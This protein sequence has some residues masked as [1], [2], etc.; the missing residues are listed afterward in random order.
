MFVNSWSLFPLSLLLFTPLPA[1][2]QEAPRPIERPQPE[3]PRP[4]PKVLPP[5]IAPPEAPKFLE[6]PATSPS[7]IQVLRYEVI[8]STVFSSEKLSEITKP[9][10]GKVS[11]DQL[12][13]AAQAITDYYLKRNYPT[14][15]A[16]VPSGQEL[17]PDNAIVQ[18]QVLE[19]KLEDIKVTG[20]QRLKSGYIQSRLA[21]ATQAP[22][23]Y[24]RLVESIRLLQQNPLLDQV[25][26]ELSAGKQP[27]TNLLEI[28]VKESNPLNLQILTENSRSPS[29]GSWQRRIQASHGNLLGY[30]DSLSLGYGNTSGSYSF[31]VGYSL[32]ITPSNT[33]LSLNFGLTRSNVIEAPF[34]EL[35]IISKS[36]YYEVT[37]RQPLFQSAQVNQTQELAIGLT[38]SRVESET[39]LLDIPFKLSEGAD[40]EGNTRITALR[41]FQE[42]LSRNSQQV[43]SFRSQFNFGLNALGSTINA[44]GPDS[45]FFSWQGQ[46]RWLRR[47]GDDFDFIVQTK[48]QLADRTLP[49]LEQFSIGGA[50][51]VR[52]YRQDVRTSDNGIFGSVELQIP[53][54]RSRDRTRTFQITPFADIGKVWSNDPFT[55]LNQP[56]LASTGLGL[57]WRSNHW[58]ARM[59]W[60]IPLVQLEGTKKSLQESGLHLS[61]RYSF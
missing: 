29:I 13:E 39:S 9:F 56:L 58:T 30:G 52:G 54:W 53:L 43:L 31:D 37:L 47:L 55:T 26:A 44:S 14:T 32:P 38:G 40:P 1:I 7:Q 10:T 46:G 12:Q 24:D 28:K 49:S 35:D 25:T 51:T 4:L 11:F 23:N 45:R 3:A 5:A 50:S 48:I 6:L 41:F 33:T 8:G 16:Y 18:I 2:A 22:L 60:G 21:R 59:D 20:N 15:G 27:G 34:N 19:G 36:R 61:V 42:Y 17:K 57:L